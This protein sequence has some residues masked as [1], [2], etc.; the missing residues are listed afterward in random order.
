MQPE[1]FWNL[2]PYELSLRLA[3]YSEEKAEHRQELIYLAWHIEAFARQ[4]RLPGLAKLLKDKEGSK[5]T[6]KH[7]STEQLMK[8]AQSKGLKV[9]RNWR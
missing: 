5:K 1:D 6:K 2:T 3:G 9:P 8:I 7:L 4:K